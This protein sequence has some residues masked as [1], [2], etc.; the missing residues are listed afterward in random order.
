MADV[1]NSKVPYQ[2]HNLAVDLPFELDPPMDPV[3]WREVAAHD[4]G[5]LWPRECLEIELRRGKYGTDSHID[6]PGPVRSVY[7]QYRPSP[8]ARA[9]GLEEHLGT[10]DEIYYKREDLNPGG[11]H[12]LNTA[13][14]QA[15]YAAQDGVHTLVTDTG[16]G[17]W[18]TA[19]ALA[20]ARFGLGLKVF[21]V[22]KSFEEKP[23]RRTLMRML[24]AEVFLS[25]SELTETG[26]G[27]LKS[28]PD[29]PGSLGIGMSEAIELVRDSSGHRLALGC[30]SYYAAMHQTVIGLE[31]RDQLAV[32]DR[33]PDVLVGCV[34]GGSNLTGFVS[35]FV[36][37]GDADR[38]RCVAAESAAVPVLTQGEF[39]YDWADFGRQTPRI[40]MYTLGSDFIPPAIH[41][42]G[43]RYHGKT[44]ILSALV[45]H[46]MV[47]PVAFDQQEVLEAGRLFLKTEGVLLAP[48][49]CHAVRAAIDEVRNGAGGSPRVIVICVSGHGYLDLQAYADALDLG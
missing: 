9:R 21:M 7:E 49:S 40:R 17:Q 2:W 12:K 44:P 3:E 4:F 28:D 20:C 47:S 13:L 43:L 26:R 37:A 16:A 22:R 31:L 46:G 15:Y 33:T 6:I 27:V 30:M 36:T 18:G 48:E 29:G 11:S 14:A 41:A 8:L 10:R 19:L 34:G 5:W 24:G 42:G 35:P 25:P 23:Y 39:R 38:P 32:I 1:I 45:K